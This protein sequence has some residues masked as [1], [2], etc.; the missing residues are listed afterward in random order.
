MQ[1]LVTIYMQAET[2]ER[3]DVTQ[4]FTSSAIWLEDHNFAFMDFSLGPESESYTPNPN[5]S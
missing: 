2:S 5:V 3:C 4:Y 1:L